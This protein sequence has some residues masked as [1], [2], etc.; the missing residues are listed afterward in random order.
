[1]RLAF[2]P[3]PN[4]TFVFHAWTHGLLDG[5]PTT[6]VTYADIDVTNTAAERG[7]FDVIKVSYAA[8]P[9]LMIEALVL[10]SVVPIAA[11]GAF[12]G[13]SGRGF[14]RMIESKVDW[15][16]PRAGELVRMMREGR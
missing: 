16:A 9:W 14:L 7:E 4:D 2:S 3:C 8:L 12:G 11:T 10:E 6:E 1:M 15:I 5:A 13:L